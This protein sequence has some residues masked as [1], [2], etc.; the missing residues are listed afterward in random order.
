MAV[1]RLAAAPAL[2]LVALAGCSDDD[3]GHAHTEIAIH[4]FQFDPAQATAEEGMVL[5][6]NHDSAPHTATADNGAFDTGNLDQDEEYEV[7][8]PSG[9]Y[10]YHCKLHT[11]MRGTLTVP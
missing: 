3:G 6:V 11:Q 10:S 8:L 2:L 7:E 1:L 5:F 4:N 9:T